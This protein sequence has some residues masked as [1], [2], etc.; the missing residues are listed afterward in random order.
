MVAQLG[1]EN[2]LADKRGASRG[3]LRVSHLYKLMGK[4]FYLCI[5][6]PLNVQLNVWG[7]WCVYLLRLFLLE[8]SVACIKLFL[9]HIKYK[10]VPLVLWHIFISFSLIKTQLI[11]GFNLVE[12]CPQCVLSYGVYVL[13]QMARSGAIWD[14]LGRVQVLPLIFL[15]FHLWFLYIWAPFLIKWVITTWT[16]KHSTRLVKDIRHT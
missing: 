3:V 14:L 13:G 11:L 9:V 4:R 6:V 10:K 15:Y 5:W 16:H 8:G 7:Q 12:V 2:T 1:G